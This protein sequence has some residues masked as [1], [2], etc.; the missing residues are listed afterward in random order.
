MLDYIKEQFKQH[1]I[2]CGSVAFITVITVCG[3]V[4][5]LL[6][7]KNLLGVSVSSQNLTIDRKLQLPNDVD[8]QGEWVYQSESNEEKVFIEDSCKNRYGRVNI[9]HVA[10]YEIRLSGE[11]MTTGNCK[12]RDPNSQRQIEKVAL[13]SKIAFVIPQRKLVVFQIDTQDRIPSTFYITTNIKKDPNEVKPSEMTGT[14]TYL[15][16]ARKTWFRGRI[17]FY[18]ADSSK[19]QTILK[20]LP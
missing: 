5:A 3:T 7:D 16:D 17:Y 14:F 11:R 18:K 13:D 9:N 19:A 6:H 1:P 4:I 10:D 20:K 12:T 15:N 8:I 2:I